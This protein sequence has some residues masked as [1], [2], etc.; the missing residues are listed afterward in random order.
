MGL[1]PFLIVSVILVGS[2]LIGKPSTKEVETKKVEVVAKKESSKIKPTVNEVKPEP[3][4]EVKPEP[5]TEEVNTEE[6]EKNYFKLIMYIIAGI[7]A[8]FAGTYFFSNRKNAQSVSSTVDN[9][10]KDSEEEVQ[11]ETVEPPQP[12]EEEVQSETV[13]P[14]QTDE[15]ENNNK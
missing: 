6:T 3:V 7:A 8:I 14:Q 2:N 1:L 15:D 10:R 11:S 9:S 4:K 5:V 13:E 12:A